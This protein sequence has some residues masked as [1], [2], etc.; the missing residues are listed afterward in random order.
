MDNY[1]QS[2]PAR[3]SDARIW[4]DYRTSHRRE[5]YNMHINGFNRSDDFR[6]FYQKNADQLLDNEW[7]NM[8]NVSCHTYPC[9]HNYPTRPTQGH[10]YEEMNV[11]NNVRTGASNKFP[12]CESL[13]DYRTTLTKNFDKQCDPKS[14]NCVKKYVARNIL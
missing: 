13:N 2:C 9:F 1:F 6:L 5:L 11:Y 7:C 12:S 8:K 14:Q 4:T 3:M 10:M